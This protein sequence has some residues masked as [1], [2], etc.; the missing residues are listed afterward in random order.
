M[1]HM[2]LFIEVATEPPSWPWR[3]RLYILFRYLNNY[4]FVSYLTSGGSRKSAKR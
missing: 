3:L 1:I 2:L 4:T